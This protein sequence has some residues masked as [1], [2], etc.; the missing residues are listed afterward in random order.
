MTLQE[1]LAQPQKPTEFQYFP[2]FEAGFGASLLGN[3]PRQTTARVSGKG[4]LSDPGLFVGN[5]DRLIQDA[6]TAAAASGVL[7]KVEVGSVGNVGGVVV[8]HLI[9]GFGTFNGLVVNAATPATGA[10]RP[11]V[12]SSESTEMSWLVQN[13]QELGRHKGEWLLIRGQQL[14]VHSPDFAELRAAVREQRINSPFVYYVPTDE[15]SNAVTI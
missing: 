11:R 13:A 14:L 5:Y 12:A 8:N 15:E 9:S 2:V 10:S 1:Q 6:A 4:P 3:Q 7:L